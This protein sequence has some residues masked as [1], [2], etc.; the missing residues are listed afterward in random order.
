MTKKRIWIVTWMVICATG[1]A[2]INAMYKIA[3]SS[4]QL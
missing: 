2:Y 4:G 3:K 1:S